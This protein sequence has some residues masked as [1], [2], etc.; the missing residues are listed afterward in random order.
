ML[1]ALRGPRRS[2][3][4]QDVG[5][6]ELAATDLLFSIEKPRSGAVAQ[7][8]LAFKHASQEMKWDRE[9]C[10]AA[11]AQDWRALQWASE[12]MKNDEQF[13]LAAIN[14]GTNNNYIPRLDFFFKNYI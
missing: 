3:G 10:K 4:C 6:I 7:N 9:V 11:V 2:P 12:E 14:S 1:D 8:G 13:L 5:L